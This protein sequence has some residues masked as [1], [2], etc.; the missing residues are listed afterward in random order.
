MAIQKAILRFDLNQD[1]APPDAAM[2]WRGHD[3]REWATQE[4]GRADRR[5][6]AS[7][8]VVARTDGVTSRTSPC[9]PTG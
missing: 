4:D 7:R 5:R 2:S 1:R 6:G 8:L 9:R 3:N